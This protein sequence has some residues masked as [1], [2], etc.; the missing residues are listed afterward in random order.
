MAV[1]M[2]VLARY[3]LMPFVLI[4]VTLFAMGLH[5]VG[6]SLHHQFAWHQTVA[7]V[8]DVS[9]Y[10]ETHKN[11]LATKGI[12]VA[13][14]YVANDAPMIWSGKGKLIG[15]YTASKGDR[16]ELYYDPADPS[17]LDTAAMKGWGGG[18][19]L[20]AVTGGFTAFYVWFFWLRGRNAPPP[21]SSAGR[22][23]SAGQPQPQRGTFGRR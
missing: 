12:N 17:S 23:A 10:T 2:F 19:L 6:T 13:I 1:V 3:L 20:F 8:M 21:M 7:T 5:I 18:L 15:L 22:V 14:A 11:G 4:A 16:V 9:P